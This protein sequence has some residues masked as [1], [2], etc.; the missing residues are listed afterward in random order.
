MSVPANVVALQNKV[1]ALELVLNT[2][3]GQFDHHIGHML[4]IREILRGLAMHHLS[5]QLD[6]NHTEDLGKSIDEWCD[7]LESHA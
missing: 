2:L 7:H 4:E 3:R 1:A 6:S 5:G